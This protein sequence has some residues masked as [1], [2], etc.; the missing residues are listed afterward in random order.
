MY[1]LLTSVFTFFQSRLEKRISK[2]YVRT[3]CGGAGRRRTQFI[4]GVAG[5]G[6]AGGAAT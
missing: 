6:A 4:P 5:G 2:G 1:W 3:E